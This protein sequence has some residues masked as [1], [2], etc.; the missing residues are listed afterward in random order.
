M[1]PELRR[2]PL[3][4]TVWKVLGRRLVTYA[5]LHGEHEIPHR[6]VRRRM[7]LHQPASSR[8]H[9]TRTSQAPRLEGDP[10]CRFLR[11]EERLPLAVAAPR[12]PAVEDRLRLV[13]E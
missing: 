10:R 1:C 4:E 2:I 12:V 13:Q 8:A 6:S 11:A 7:A 9:G 5:V 3:L